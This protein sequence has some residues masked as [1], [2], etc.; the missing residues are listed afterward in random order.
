[1]SNQVFRTPLR[2][3]N[4]TCEQSDQPLLEF[5]VIHKDITVVRVY[6]W[7][8]DCIID[9]VAFTPNGN[10]CIFQQRCVRSNLWS[11]LEFIIEFA[12]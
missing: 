2:F 5:K 8:R 9:V 10:H 12:Q 11:T 7:H 1:M 3:A 6:T 4:E